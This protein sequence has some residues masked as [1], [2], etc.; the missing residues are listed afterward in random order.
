VKR[1]TWNWTFSIQRLADGLGYEA[2]LEELLAPVNGKVW[3][4]AEEKPMLLSMIEFKKYPIVGVFADTITADKRKEIP[5]HIATVNTSVELYVTRKG[6]VGSRYRYYTQNKVGREDV[7]ALLFGCSVPVI[8]RPR[9]GAD[10]YEL[11]GE[12]Y[13]H[14]IM[15]GEAFEGSGMEDVQWINI[16]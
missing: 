10:G 9:K 12:T 8:L 1:R 16:H 7:V 6:Y 14:G 13:V 15:N 2:G 5:S 11:V 4:S 3:A